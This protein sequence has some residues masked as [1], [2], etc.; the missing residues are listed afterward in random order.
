MRH[1]L[2]PRP[3]AG[4][5]DLLQMR[6]LLMEGRART[7][8]WRYAHVGEL[9]FSHFMVACHLDPQ[10]HIRLWHDEGGELAGFAILGEDPS[11]DWQVLPEYEW[12]G[13]EEEALAWAEARV[14]ALREQ[15]P[16]RWSGPLAAGARQDDAGRLD[17]LERHGFR[18]RGEFAEVN[19]LRSLAGPI[20]EGA[21]P[22]RFL[23]RALAEE[24]EV[25]ERASAHREV[26]QP[27]TVG[28]VGDDDYAAFRRLPGYDRQ[29][30]VVAVAPSGV[31]AAYV[32]CWLDPVNRIGDFGPVGA[33]RAFRR[34]GL[35][36]AVLLEGLRRLQ[37][38]GMDRVCVS[39]GV[40]N[41]AA[42]RLYES[43][44]FEVV[45]QYLDF[46]K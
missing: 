18:Y 17:F 1:A 26:W 16:A 11:L 43:V 9:A 20:P 29:L 42:R 3:Y 15:E 23:V 5:A 38:A 10:Q 24:G 21:L 14:A 41:T 34:Q 19:M 4:E 46:V 32:N 45:N 25:P 33:R 2:T 37:A 30:D 22:E 12:W 40:A 27:W 35:T 8:D 44:G 7:S 6:G 36:R 28:Q 39:T 31:I 13:L